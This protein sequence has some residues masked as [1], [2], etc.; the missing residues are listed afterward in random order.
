MAAARERSNEIVLIDVGSLASLQDELRDAGLSTPQS[1]CIFN[2]PTILF[3]HNENSFLPNCFSIGPVH[4]GKNHLV[5][6]EKIKMKYLK[7]CV[8]RV[9]TSRHGTMSQ[10]SKEVEEQ[11]VLSDLINSVQSIEK[12]ASA[13]YAGHDFA[14]ELGD[15]FVRTM[16]LDGV[17]VIELFRK[18]SEKVKEHGDPIFSMSCMLQYLYHD[19]I[20]LK[21]Q[22]PWLVLELLFEK[23]SLLNETKSLIV[24]ALLFFANTFTS[25]PPPVQTS[26]IK[27]KPTNGWQPIRSVTRLKEA[28]VKFKKGTADTVLDIKFNNG[29]LEIPSLFIQETTEPIFRNL[30][31][32]EQCFGRCQPIFTCY[33]KLLDNLIDTNNDMEILCKNEIIDNWLSLE[34]S[35]RFFNNLYND[36][37]IK[38]FYYSEL[39]DKLDSHC[40]RWWPRWRAAYVHNYF[41]KPWAIA[42][43]IYAVIMLFLTIKHAA[44]EKYSD[45][46]ICFLCY[47]MA[48]ESG[49]SNENVVIDVGYLVSSLNVELRDARLSMPQSYCIFNIPRILL[50]HNK[51]SFVPNCF[52]IGPM[53][54]GKENLVAAER[55]KIKY[56]KA[57][58]SRV[59]T[60]RHGTMSRE[61][62]E[63]EEQK[64]LSDLINVV[65][66]IEKQA[67]AC[68]AGHDFA[69][70][71]GGEFVKTMLL[72]GVFVVA[73]ESN[74]LETKN[75]P[76]TEWQPI[77]SITK[78]KE[79]RVKFKKV[80]PDS[81]LVIKFTDGCLEIPSLLIQETTQTIFRNLIAYEQC[82]PHCPPIFTCYAKLLDNLIDTNNDMEILCKSDIFDNWLSLA[83]S[84]QF[85]N[86]LYNDTYV[87]EFYYSE[88]SE[89]LDHHCK[90]WWPRWRAYYVHNYFTKPWAVA[91][92][93]YAVI[94]FVLTLWQT[95]K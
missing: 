15:E 35:T 34:D 2:I 87:K 88:L 55:I 72:D 10:E 29:C 33:A 9:I 76:T 45:A 26:Q 30:I 31:A 49:R 79:A 25:H 50:R 43:Q 47:K 20:L 23:T 91:A 62:K 71:L 18:D 65:K 64:V 66:S 27:N 58:L 44:S 19:L 8:S 52:A 46:T 67:S 56:L 70:E 82:L 42:A 32:Y 3:R 40:R 69:A 60:G 89:K 53:H 61:S 78:L 51:N 28:G 17:F 83:D 57:C 86:N 74:P 68:Y 93:I 12:Q 39:S 7:A 11:K 21:N 24:L 16:L 84:T 77:H 80:A 85:F 59:I 22:I 95:Y 38:E 81:I 90:R 1:Y 37:Y 73:R 48:A 63:V 41:T 5:A 92:Q 13:C 54:R 14:A 4:R 6:T 36:T 75:K 94:M